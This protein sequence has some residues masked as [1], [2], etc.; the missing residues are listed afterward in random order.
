MLRDIKR[1]CHRCNTKLPVIQRILAIYDW[2][3]QCKKCGHMM[4]TSLLVLF[5]N[6]LISQYFGYLVVRAMLIE[7]NYN[8]FFITEVWALFIFLPLISIVS[9]G[10]IKH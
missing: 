9:F 1:S 7:R 10:V 3:I 4:E 6:M 5:A 8:F 2:S